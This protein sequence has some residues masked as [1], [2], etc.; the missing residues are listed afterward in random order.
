M[1]RRVHRKHIGLL[2]TV[3]A[4]LVVAG[5]SSGSDDASPTTTVP[6]QVDVD[7]GLSRSE[8]IAKV[9]P[10]YSSY[11]VEMVTV[12]GGEFWAPY[13]AA[14]AKADRPPLDLASPRL[15][16]LAKALGPAYIR[17]S[18]TWANSVYF[19]P[20]GTPDEPVPDGFS[21]VLTG[22]Q[23]KGVGAFAD[24]VDG[25]IITSFP[26]SPGAFDADGKWK[27]DEAVKRIAFS[28]ANHIPL[29][30]AE[31]FNES[32]LPVALPQGY[33]AAEFARDFSTLAGVVDDSAQDLELV[34]PSITNDI[35]PMILKP[36]IKGSDITE[37]VGSD[38]DVFSYHFYPK[39]SQ[40]CGGK[41][42]PATGLEASYLDKID[43]THAYYRKLRDTDAPGA[44]IWV[45]ETAQ[46]ACGGDPWSSEFVDVI[47]L[48]DTFG[49][50]A[51]GD[52][53][54]VFH[55]T[56][57]GSDY[58]Y[59]SEDGFATHPIYW[60]AVLWH[61]L[62]GPT[63]LAP[64]A[65]G[66]PEIRVHAQCTPDGDGATYA[67]INTSATKSQ[68]VTGTSDKATTYQLTG[69]SLDSPDVKLNGTRLVAAE[70]GTLPAMQ[71][72]SVRGAIT[73]PPASV[74][75]VVDPTPVP[76]CR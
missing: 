34:G 6:L 33:T 58:A 49:K 13:D 2:A 51:D 43:K 5:C 55:N 73:V 26:S 59:L 18:G 19:D 31:L 36:S 54:A 70:D 41:G 9:D 63:V 71:G 22:A 30:G 12:T 8:P 37:L 4:L 69:E 72:K 23:W 66:S 64:S 1:T 25:E 56:L 75:F 35:D 27:P 53:N 16:N 57:V 76:A 47:R 7:L 48:V 67:V 40:R 20:D 44:P 46:A 52:G 38:L 39:G 14:E 45:T 11:N 21:T 3:A 74:T 42:T 32:N 29:V 60:A 17:V 10:R 15:R 61:R 50:L 24:A 65:S 28:R 62:M 68:T